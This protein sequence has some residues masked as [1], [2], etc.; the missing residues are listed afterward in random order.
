[1]NFVNEG[2]RTSERIMT[3]GG[4]AMSL[5]SP[6]AVNY[7]N[8]TPSHMRAAGFHVPNNGNKWFGRVMAMEERSSKST[9]P[10]ER[11]M[12]P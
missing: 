4:I 5:G 10:P 11:S 1:L 2:G 9:Y 7:L 8:P 3:A 6:G 12:L